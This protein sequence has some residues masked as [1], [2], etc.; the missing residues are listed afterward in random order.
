M[1][2]AATHGQPQQPSTVP[3]STTRT[4]IPGTQPTNQNTWPIQ[5]PN[6]QLRAL[7]PLTANVTI[8]RLKV[9][10]KARMGM[11]SRRLDFSIAL[12][13]YYC[14]PIEQSLCGVWRSH[15]PIAPNMKFTMF[16]YSPPVFS[17]PGAPRTHCRRLRGGR[18]SAAVG[19]PQHTRVASA[20]CTQHRRAASAVDTNIDA[21][22]LLAALLD[23]T[24]ADEK[25]CASRPRRPRTSYLTSPR[26]PF[27]D[28]SWVSSLS[29]SRSQSP[30]YVVLQAPRQRCR[31]LRV[32]TSGALFRTAWDT[33]S[34][35]LSVSS[36]EELK[37]DSS[38]TSVSET[39]DYSPCV[40]PPMA[41]SS[42]QTINAY[43]RTPVGTPPAGLATLQGTVNAPAA[44]RIRLRRLQMAAR[45]AAALDALAAEMG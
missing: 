21:N 3:T 41:R 13:H 9:V 12:A 44:P 43:L 22:A 42:S 40:S 24:S 25:W 19:S 38:A 16:K 28:D 11:G 17:P 36:L 18:S 7:E 8:L 35:T 31:R 23:E 32:N 33:V 20:P 4:H 15:S 34:P 5:A 14:S 26:S 45:A 39:K 27:S 1:T 29:S 6:L 30:Q 2:T 10:Q 37:S